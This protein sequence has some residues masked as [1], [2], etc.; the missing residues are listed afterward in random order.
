MSTANSKQARYDTDEL[1]AALHAETRLRVETEERSRRNREEFQEFILNAAHDLREQLRTVSA[2]CELLTRKDAE[3]AADDA[4]QFRRYIL[5]GTGKIQNLIA[6]M[7]EYATAGADSKYV[8]RIDIADVL[9][10]AMAYPSSASAQP[11]PPVTYDWLPAVKGDFEK[12]VKVFRHLLDNA[13]KYCDAPE[14]RVHVSARRD[15]G[16]DGANWVLMVQDNGSGIDYAYQERIFAPFKRLHGRQHPGLG[17]GLSYCQKAVE[18]H[19]GRIWVEA[20]PGKGSVFCF[21]L[22]AAD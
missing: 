7:V 11:I 4:D 22:P 2:Y 1:Q 12:L 18:S 16:N 5:D 20:R 13:A 10:E 15:G 19:G 21:T 8:L 3:Q 14:P 17:L 9:R 6:G